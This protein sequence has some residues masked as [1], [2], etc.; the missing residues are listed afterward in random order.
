MSADLAHAQT[1]VPA[2]GRLGQDLA[3]VVG[4]DPPDSLQLVGLENE[5]ERLA[6]RKDAKT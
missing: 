2:A 5:L 3:P 4:D 6:G 1:H